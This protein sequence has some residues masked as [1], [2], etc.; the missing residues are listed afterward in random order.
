MPLPPTTPSG[1]TADWRALAKS[2]HDLAIGGVPN[3]LRVR[4]WSQA[5]GAARLM[6]LYP[7]HFTDMLAVGQ[8]LHEHDRNEIE[9]DLG[10]T[11]P[12]HP[13]FAGDAIL[14]DSA[15]VKP[16]SAADAA[17]NRPA[18]PQLEPRGRTALRRVL[19]AYV[20]H[21]RGLGYCQALNYVGGMLLLLTELREELAFFLMIH[22]TERCVTDFY[23]KYMTGI[24]LEQKLFEDVFRAPLPRPAAPIPAT[25]LVPK[26]PHSTM[27]AW[28]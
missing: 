25:E 22:L 10:R 19:L 1:T 15:P 8:S 21:N 16:S 17:D 27:R 5:S 23:S 2:A 7:T 11:F 3:S 28:G 13:L 12:D 4:V 24:R 9:I 18:S 6:A 14:S 26:F 20:A